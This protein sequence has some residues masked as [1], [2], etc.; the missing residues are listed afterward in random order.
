MTTRRKILGWLLK[1]LAKL[2]IWRYRPGVIGVTG[3]VGK[4][5]TKLAI[6]TV[7]E[8]DRLV[9]VSR[10]NFNNKIG[11]SLATLGDY[12]QDSELAFWSIR[13]I[14]FWMRVIIAACWNVLFK[15]RKYPEL[16]VLE[17]GVDRP[18]EMRELLDIARPNIGVITAVG[19]IP[20]HVEFFAGPEMVAR[21]KARLI[22]Y[23]PAAGFAI[24]NYDDAAVNALRERTRAKVFSFGFGAGA[25]MRVTNFENKSDDGKP[26]GIAFKLE[27]GGSFVPVRIDGVFGKAQAYAAAAAACVGLIF[28]MNLVKIAEALKNYK[29]LYGRMT[30]IS[31]IKDTFIIDDSYNASPLSMHAALD[32]LKS[33]KAKRK[34]AVLGDMLEIGKYAPEAHEEIGRLAAKTVNVLFVVGPRAKFI[35][36]SARHHG[37]DKRR[38]FSFD[39]IDGAGIAVQDALRKGDL[40]LVKASR[41]MRFDKIVEEIKDLTQERKP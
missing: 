12:G 18:N 39:T 41:S 3:S 2:V 15:K 1:V 4:T 23:L 11:L 9:R 30:L 16:L 17:Y 14:F 40:V 22:E 10:S 38:I 28:G 31:G 7:L 13:G 36:E 25:D 8:R 33:L 35:A 29:P 5:S 26:L 24:L 19:D 20:V 21:E 34:I 6:A 32:T 37:L 27:Y